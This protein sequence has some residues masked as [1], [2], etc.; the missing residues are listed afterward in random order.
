M[1]AHLAVVQP[2]DPTR[3]V[4]P[5]TTRSIGR[6]LSLEDTGRQGS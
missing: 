4:G 1:S 3:L 6:V 5:V 2:G